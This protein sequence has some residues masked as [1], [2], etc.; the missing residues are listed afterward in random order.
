[1]TFSF[2]LL[3]AIPK[4]IGHILNL[5][6]GNVPEEPKQ[7]RCTCLRVYDTPEG[8]ETCDHPMHKERDDEG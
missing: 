5:R 4:F 1:M 2:S 7:Y 8:V 6:P 3:R